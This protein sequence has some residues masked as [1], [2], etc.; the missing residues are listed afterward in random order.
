MKNFISVALLF[1]GFWP[2]VHPNS[3]HIDITVKG[4]NNADFILAHYINKSMY[5]DDTVTADENG[6]GIFI[7]DKPLPQGMYLIFLPNGK[8]FDIMMGEDQQYVL[9]TDTADFIRSMQVEGSRENEVFFDFQ[10][11]MI[12]KKTELDELQSEYKTTDDSKKK[13]KLRVKMESLNNERKEYAQ[14]IIDDHRGFFISTF[15]AATLEIEIPEPPRDENGAIIDSSWAYWYNRNHYFNNFDIADAR[16]LRTPLYEDKIL[17]YIDKILPQIP[18]TL[19]AES[20][21][22]LQQVHGDST[23]YRYSL[24]TLF[25]H[26]GKSKLMGME[27]VQVYIAEKYYIPD[28]WWST[29]DYIKDL[30]KRVAA[31]KPTLI[32]QPAPNVQL[33]FIPAEH[34]QAAT[35]DTGLKKYPHAGS[36]FNIDDVQADFTVLLF[37]EATCS[38]CKKVVPDMYDIYINQLKDKGVKV[39]AISTLFGEDGKVKWVDFVNNKGLYEWLNAWNPYD[40]Q[41]KI[42]YDINSTPQIFILDKDKKI[43]AK[44]IGPEQVP[45][46]IEAYKKYNK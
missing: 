17:T 28:S 45:E 31:L 6:R 46:I 11:Y 25:N 3:Y 38:H 44:R 24:I 29:D 1:I 10:K 34:F 15:L 23:L 12:A 36:F 37:W 30:E 26:F 27:A 2:N 41:Y 35:A 43:I 8:Y 9:V 40:Y 32:G 39:I 18:D 20:D 22:I 21:K 42:T 13:V 19:I 7:G 16:L 5:P 4:M 33:R 14:K